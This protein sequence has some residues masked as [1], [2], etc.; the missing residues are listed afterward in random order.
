MTRGAIPEPALFPGQTVSERALAESF[1]PSQCFVR[2]PD[3]DVPVRFS[4]LK[5]PSKL[6]VAAHGGLAGLVALQ[7]VTQ[8]N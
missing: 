7:S 1:S 4:P 6:A 3:P 8:N 5:H 2:D